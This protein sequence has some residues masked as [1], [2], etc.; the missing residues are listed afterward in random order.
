MSSEMAL[1]IRQLIQER[2]ISEEL[3]LHTIED[4]LLAAYKRKFGTID[5]A[6]V[7]FAEDGADVSIYAQKRIVPVDEIDDPALEIS[8]TDAL[9]YNDDAELGDELLIEINPRDFDRVSI[10]SAK[11]KARQ[12]LREIQ[13]DTLYSE[14]KDREGELIV[15]LLSARGAMARFS[16][17]SAAPRAFCHAAT[18]RRV[19]SIAPMTAY[20]R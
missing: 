19:R 9:E 17:T 8:L 10:Q 5:N 13:K 3:V 16:W 15:G 20:G 1:A 2:G 6:V 4:T 11:Q 12:S 18:S 14:F 7:R